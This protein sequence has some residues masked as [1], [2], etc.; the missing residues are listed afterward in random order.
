VC[1][2]WLDPFNPVTIIPSPPVYLTRAVGTAGSITFSCNSGSYPLV[3]KA[4]RHYAGCGSDLSA[5]MRYPCGSPTQKVNTCNVS[6]G[7]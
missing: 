4:V 6:Y 3:L 2:Y 5:A 1:S 7:G